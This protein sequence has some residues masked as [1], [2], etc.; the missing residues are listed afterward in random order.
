MSFSQRA[1]RWAN[2]ALVVTVTKRDFEALNY[3][4]PLA[5]VEFQVVLN[6]SVV[7]FCYL[8]LNIAFIMNKGFTNIYPREEIKT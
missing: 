8:Y 5:G 1:S 7:F 6:S 3:H 2:A 4:G